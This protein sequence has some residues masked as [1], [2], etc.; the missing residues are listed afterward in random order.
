MTQAAATLLQLLQFDMHVPRA[1][2]RMQHKI[3]P[4]QRAS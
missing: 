3:M 1:P 4:I 2:Q